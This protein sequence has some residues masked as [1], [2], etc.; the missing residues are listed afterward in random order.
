M[1]NYIL[2]HKFIECMI[3]IMLSYATTVRKLVTWQA[4]ALI[5]TMVNPQSV[6]SVRVHTKHENV[7]K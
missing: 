7:M 2:N 3:R 5:K 6:E 4:N 1:T